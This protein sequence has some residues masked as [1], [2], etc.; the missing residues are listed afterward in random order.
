MFSDHDLDRQR[1][2]QLVGRIKPRDARSYATANG[3]VRKTQDYGG[4][5]VFDHRQRELTQLLIPIESTSSDYP[6]R[7]LDVVQ[8][9]AEVEE[10]SL[11]QLAN[12]LL[13]P[14]ADVVRYRISDPTISADLALLKGIET[15]EGAKRT[16]L[17]AAHSVL[18]PSPYHPRLSR[19]EA[20]DFVDHC[21]LKQTEHGSFVLA[22]A[23][24]LDAVDAVD[25]EG[26]L[27]DDNSF[28][29]QV[30]SLLM[31]SLIRIE[32]RINADD[33]ASL[34]VNSSEQAAI[35]AN[36]CDALT[37]LEPPSDQGTL[38]ISTTWAS[39]APN[40]EAPQRRAVRFTEDHF[41]VI[42]E[43]A[44]RLR[45][46]HQAEVANFVGQVETLNGDLNDQ[47]RRYGEVILDL[48]VDDELVQARVELDP[49]H[50][51]IADK[52][53]MDGQP[54]II[55]GE[56]HRGRRVHRLSQIASFKSAAEPGGEG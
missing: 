40:S 35:S 56:L 45:P 52:A 13:D 10:R 31:D 14:D 16:L 24:P 11:I 55:R 54:V 7:M 20:V 8:R 33:E 6:T 18:K 26:L 34:T 46:S 3:W 28:T 5:A 38:E 49:D 32:E 1:L 17:A 39:T 22:I 12:D 51:A 50:Y 25:A 42:R 37:R 19:R 48:L 2:L 15:L 27:R 23:C 9:L 41:K 30:T 43:V 29:R 36:L 44:V 21:R 53:H 4:L 47:G